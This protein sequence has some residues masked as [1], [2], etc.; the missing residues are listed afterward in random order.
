MVKTQIK[1]VYANCDIDTHDLYRWWLK[2]Y[3]H[4]GVNICAELAILL[5]NSFSMGNSHPVIQL[6]P[7]LNGFPEFMELFQKVLNKYD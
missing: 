3:H 7:K 2:R 5:P 6:T 4:V 1:T